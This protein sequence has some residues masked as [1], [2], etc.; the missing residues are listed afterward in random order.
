MN[1]AGFIGGNQLGRVATATAVL[2]LA[3]N[4]DRFRDVSIDQRKSALYCWSDVAPSMTALAAAVF[5]GE[6]EAVI[7]SPAQRAASTPAW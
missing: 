3:A 4:E 6:L 5:D 7:D 1:M 2:G